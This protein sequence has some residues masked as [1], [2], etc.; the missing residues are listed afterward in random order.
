MKNIQ[1]VK[2]VEYHKRLVCKGEG[3]LRMIS[4]FFCMDDCTLILPME[5]GVVEK[6]SLKD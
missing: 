3:G 6:T 4:R 5:I 2:S 1:K